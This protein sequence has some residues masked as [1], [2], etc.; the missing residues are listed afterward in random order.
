MRHT[1][2][3]SAQ[4]VERFNYKNVDWKAYKE[5]LENNLTELVNLLTSPIKTPCTIKTA[6][7][8][9]FKAINKTTREVVL[10]IKIT[11]PMKCWWTKELTLLRKDRNRANAEHYRWRSLPDHPSHLH[12]KEIGGEFTR[13]IEKAKAD[14]WQEWINHATSAKRNKTLWT[15]E[16]SRAL[17]SSQSLIIFC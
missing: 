17:Q 8:L 10:V 7:D 3:G 1:Y 14:H 5:T 9:L 2:I 16:Y 13:A 12:Y 4:H 6:T 11:P 15:P